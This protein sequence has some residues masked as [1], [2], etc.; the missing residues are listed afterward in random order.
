MPLG[1]A[2]LNNCTVVWRHAF[3]LCSVTNSLAVKFDASR[4][5]GSASDLMRT[6]NALRFCAVRGFPRRAVEN[7]AQHTHTCLNSMHQQGCV[8]KLQQCFNNEHISQFHKDETWFNLAR[9]LAPLQAIHSPWERIG[10]IARS[11]DTANSCKHLKDGWP[12]RS[13]K[14]SWKHRRRRQYNVNAP[15]H[16]VAS[17]RSSFPCGSRLQLRVATCLAC[18]KF[19]RNIP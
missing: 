14:P 15:F 12:R 17:S 10:C 4:P 9:H 5:H 3:H 2:A 19:H 16:T 11:C 18:A 1:I 8:N 13:N 6:G 7:V